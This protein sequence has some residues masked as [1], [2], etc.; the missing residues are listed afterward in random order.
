MP[1]WIAQ[2]YLVT[3]N[4]QYTNTPIH[5]YTNTVFS[6]DLTSIRERFM[7]FQLEE[8]LQLY[9]LIDKT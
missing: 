5:Q 2:D 8:E 1:R 3:L 9:I 6:H 4:E 7:Q